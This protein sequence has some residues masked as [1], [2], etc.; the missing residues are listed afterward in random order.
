MKIYRH[1]H[2]INF[3]STG[4]L[5]SITHRKRSHRFGE[6]FFT[7][8]EI[9]RAEKGFILLHVKARLNNLA[10]KTGPFVQLLGISKFSS[11]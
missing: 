8:T 2:S 7:L 9:F 11:A 5:N 10:T 6:R 1:N 3:Q 4:N